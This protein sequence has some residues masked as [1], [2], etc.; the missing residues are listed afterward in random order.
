[1]ARK[2]RFLEV[3]ATMSHYPSH[4][5]KTRR[6]F[7]AYM[8]LLDTAEW[9]KSELRGP[10][11]SFDLTMGE[12]RVLELLYRE[13]A[14]FVADV[15]RRRKMHRQSMDEVIARLGERRW[16]A[17]RI[18][19]LPPVEFERTHLPASK[20]DEPREGRRVAVVGLTRAGKK[21]MGNV[22]PVHS[23]LVR[24]LLR[25]LNAKEQDS[26]SRLCRKLREGDVLKFAAEITHEEVE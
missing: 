13:G 10:L 4:K 20:R 14:L 24:A 21:F 6:A 16:V 17:R 3:F 23:K 8:D 12:F 2:R 5:E 25:V 11:M 1:M 19:A 26:L 18:V 22:L 15:A 7:R 9:L